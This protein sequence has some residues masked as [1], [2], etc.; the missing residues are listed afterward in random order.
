M[1][2]LVKFAYKIGMLIAGS[3]SPKSVDPVKSDFIAQV[4]LWAFQSFS[5]DKWQQVS[6]EE[7]IEGALVSA[8]EQYKLRLV[9]FYSLPEIMSV[10]RSK[11]LVQD[12]W[13]HSSNVW[14]ARNLFGKKDP[15]KFV[16]LAVREA[17]KQQERNLRHGRIIARG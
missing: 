17:R 1:L 4:G 8:P 9:D 7:I 2:F 14:I 6:D 10:W 11:V 15:E 3:I 5:K 16:N 12:D 13:L